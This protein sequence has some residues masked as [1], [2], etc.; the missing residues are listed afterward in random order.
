M[1]LEPRLLDVDGSEWERL[2]LQTARQEVPSTEVDDKLLS[3]LVGL[4][5]AGGSASATY[6]S[7]ALVKWAAASA[8]V[9]LG[10]GY[11]VWPS[12]E[13]S[14]TE[15]SQ[16]FVEAPQEDPSEGASRVGEAESD[17]SFETGAA[18]EVPPVPSSQKGAQGTGAG[19]GAHQ[20]E[21]NA[22]SG[23]KPNS[24]LAEE[25][26]L[27]DQARAD[28]KQGEAEAALVVLGRYDQSYPHGVLRQEATVLRVTALKESGH[29]KEASQLGDS[30]LEAHPTSAHKRRLETEGGK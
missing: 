25:M 13:E 20:K 5:L 19:R 17:S 15:V 11:A 10:V 14:R 6:G 30:F 28:L 3:P 26:R 22:E 7:S 12:A 24:T 29:K 18:E 8:A 4:P 9:A 27:L 23:A 21:P 2:L 16:P 1:T